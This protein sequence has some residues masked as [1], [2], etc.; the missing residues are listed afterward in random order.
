MSSVLPETLEVQLAKQEQ[1]IN[2]IRE[3]KDLEREW[4]KEILDLYKQYQLQRHF[5]SVVLV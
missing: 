2:R 1:R 4:S 3:A 5:E